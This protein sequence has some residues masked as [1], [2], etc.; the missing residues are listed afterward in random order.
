MAASA[1]FQSGGDGVVDADELVVLGDDLDQ[2]ALLSLN[3]M[4]FST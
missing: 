4:K 2:P 3:R 1:G